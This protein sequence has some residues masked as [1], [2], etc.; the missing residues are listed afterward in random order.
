MLELHSI[1][2]YYGSH[3]ALREVS[4]SLPRGQLTGLFGENGAGKTTLMKCILGLTRHQGEITLDGAPIS[5]RNIEKLSFA[6][7]EHSFFPGLS[8]AGHRDF[9]ADHFPG[10]RGSRFTALMDFFGLPLHKA[11]RQLSAGQ[12]NQLEVILALSQGADYILLDE[13][14]VTSDAFRREDFYK[15]LLGILEPGE[16][17]LLSTHL[18]DEVGGFLGRALVLRDGKLVGDA[19]TLALAEEGR[20]LKDY[21]QACCGYQPDRV[22]RALDQLGGGEAQL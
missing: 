20:S 22:S 10:F 18:L 11:P 12:Q 8:A 3:G 4:L 9:Y 13:P 1:S 7:G 2:K 17:V 14:F 21:V 6:T 5:R 16:T 15:V 19:D